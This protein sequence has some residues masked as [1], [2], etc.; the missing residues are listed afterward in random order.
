[1]SDDPAD[2]SGRVS[3]DGQ[4]ADAR[5]RL[6]G[7]RVVVAIYLVLTVVTGG[8]GY[9]IGVIRPDALAPTLFF[10]V[11][12]PPTPLGMA[13]YGMVTVGTILGLLLLLVRYVGREF[14]T[15][16]Q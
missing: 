4:T 16:E 1:M 3:A 12:L 8:F 2:R 11:D 9:V 14:D 15:A 10:L 5:G 6:G 7:E 13:I